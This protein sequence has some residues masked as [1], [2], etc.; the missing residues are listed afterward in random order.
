MCLAT[1]QPSGDFEEPRL[2]CEPASRPMLNGALSCVLAL[3]VGPTN[4]VAQ[5]QHSS[6]AR[7]L[8]STDNK[9]ITRTFKC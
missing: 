8:T 7:G 2:F 5:Y 3:H 1:Q 4:F 9:F 6:G